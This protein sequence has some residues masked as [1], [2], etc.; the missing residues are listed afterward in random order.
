MINK[1]SLTVEW[2]SKVSEANR[3]ADKILIE[4]AIRSLLLVE[5]M[6]KQGLN[7]IF[8]GGTALMLMMS[9][10]KRL[11]I[12]VDI[13]LP[14]MP[15]NLEDLLGRVASEQ[16]FT[17][18]EQQHR[19]TDTKI[20]K[21]HYQFFYKPVHKTIAD[22]EKILLDILFEDPGYQSIIEWPVESRFL[23]SEGK[24]N[25]VSVPSLEDLLGDKLTAFAPNTTGIPY[26][27]KGESRSMEII[28][29]LYD[30]GNLVDAAEKPAIMRATFE[31]FAS[32][33]LGYRNLAELTTEDVVE[34]IYQTSLCIV[35][36]GVAGAGDFEQLLS[37]IQRVSRF[38]FSEPF[39]LEKAIT[40][41]SKA[42]FAAMI[43]RYDAK[44]IEKFNN[45]LL[46]KDWVIG[47]PL[48]PK[49]NKLKKANPEAFFYWY[50]IYELWKE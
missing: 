43:I 23:I 10:T 22:E 38:I 30:I 18:V 7:F 1:E 33:E 5:G 6:V 20:P 17:R 29:Q 46:M 40:F 4:K 36:R 26:F 21:A 14:V 28:K 12:D 24:H 39:H 8:K 49:L 13:I 9:S 48:W 44:A 11:S 42:A 45:P 27:K 25:H 2:I 3:R 15:E 35:S 32:R 34:D 47:D 31:S 16:G 50:K 19:S 41:A 37:G